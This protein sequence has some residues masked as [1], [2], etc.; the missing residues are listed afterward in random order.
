MSVG[1]GGGSVNGDVDEDGEGGGIECIRLLLL[2]NIV[3]LSLDDV[4][5]DTGHHTMTFLD[6]VSRVVTM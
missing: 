5:N 2:C 6:H 4:C 3:V 1:N